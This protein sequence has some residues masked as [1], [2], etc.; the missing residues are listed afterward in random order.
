MFIRFI[1]SATQKLLDVETGEFA[2][3]EAYCYRW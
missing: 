3:V 2:N 1:E